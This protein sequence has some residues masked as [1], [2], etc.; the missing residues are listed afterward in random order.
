[1]WTIST[2]ADCSAF[3]PNIIR[4][5]GRFD[6][7]RARCRSRCN[8]RRAQRRVPIVSAGLLQTREDRGVIISRGAATLREGEG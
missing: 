8:T 5:Q 1:M 4:R 2:D 3:R 7:L 6:L